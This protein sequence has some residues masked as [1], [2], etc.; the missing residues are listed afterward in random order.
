M[1]PTNRTF[2]HRHVIQVTARRTS[3]SRRDIDCEVDDNLGD[4]AD[5]D[6]DR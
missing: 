4:D 3:A 5:S 6:D 1:Q 2:S